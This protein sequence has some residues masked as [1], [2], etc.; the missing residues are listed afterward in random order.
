MTL[1]FVWAGLMLDALLM[2]GSPLDDVHF[3]RGVEFQN[4]R[5]FEQ[6]MEEYELSLKSGE[7]FPVLTNLGAAYARLGRYEEAHYS[8]AP[9]TSLPPMR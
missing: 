1:R 7:R 6:A 9:R 5:K 2:L 3:S 4:A 8:A